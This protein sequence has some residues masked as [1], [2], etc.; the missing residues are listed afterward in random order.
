MRMHWCPFVRRL[1]LSGIYVSWWS[2]SPGR[3]KAMHLSSSVG[4]KLPRKQ[5]NKLCKVCEICPGKH[6]ACVFLWQ[7]T[8]FT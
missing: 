6:L 8:D 5:V 2:Q 3:T 1:V 4:R 7:T